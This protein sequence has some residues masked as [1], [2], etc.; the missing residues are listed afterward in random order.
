LPLGAIVWTWAEPLKIPLYTRVGYIFDEAKDIQ[1]LVKRQ[2]YVFRNAAVGDSY[3]IVKV[4]GH[5]HSF[6]QPPVWKGK[7][8]VRV[9]GNV[10]AA[11]QPRPLAVP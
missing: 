2:A 7:T 5:E 8:H 9:L 6:D 4:A 10:Y 3:P 11:P 1:G